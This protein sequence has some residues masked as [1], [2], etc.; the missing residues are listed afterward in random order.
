MS[1]AVQVSRSRRRPP[2]GSVCTDIPPRLSASGSWSE[3][4]IRHHVHCLLTW[5]LTNNC[6][7]AIPCSFLNRNAVYF[8]REGCCPKTR[9]ITRLPTGAL[10]AKLAAAV[11]ILRLRSCA[12]VLDRMV[13]GCLLLSMGCPVGLVV[14]STLADPAHAPV[15]LQCLPAVHLFQIVRA[16]LDRHAPGYLA[17]RGEQR[18]RTI[19]QLHRLVGNAA[20]FSPRG[21]A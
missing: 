6:R 3:L 1:H 5:R 19:R 21:R 15:P 20:S 4:V 11:P 2:V 17:H 9:G 14:P 8:L 13:A 18:Q 12:H 10:P 7:E 16:H